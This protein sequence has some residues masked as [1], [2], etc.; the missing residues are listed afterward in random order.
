ML[1]SAAS[2]Q[3]HDELAKIFSVLS[4]RYLNY[5]TTDQIL[6]DI[7]RYQ[8]LGSKDFVWNV[9][10]AADSQTRTV[11][12]C[13]KDR[14]GLFSKIAGVFTLNSIDIIDA[15]IFT[16]RNK[17]A[18]DIFEVK[19]PPD[20]LFE[21]DRWSRAEKNLSDALVDRLDLATALRKKVSGFRRR[22]SPPVRRPHRIIVDNSASKFYTIIEVFTNDYRGLLFNITDALFHCRLDI[23]VSKIATKVDPVVDVFYVRDFDGQKVEAPEQVAEIKASIEKRLIN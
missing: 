5:A 9:T 11:K 20:Q 15:R 18:V 6:E 8:R 17:I 7:G 2:G 23:W 4:P 14:P 21:E 22:K 10:R 13:A 3:D 12:I 19:P 1:A 16:W